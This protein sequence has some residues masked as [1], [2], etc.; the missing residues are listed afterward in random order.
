MSM[1][2]ITRVE[3]GW[4]HELWIYNTSKYCGKLLVFNANKKFSMHYHK[5]KQE[6]WYV[7]KG[8]FIYS[9]IDL[10]T[11]ELHKQCIKKG[12]VVTIFPHHPHQLEALEDGEIFEV[13]TQH[14]DSDSYR[15][16][17]GD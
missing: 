15:I 3:K 10:A 5:L 14:F 1:S 7:N 16:W 4:G 2:D 8:E 9:W 11:G 17:K 6:T 13:S 12:D